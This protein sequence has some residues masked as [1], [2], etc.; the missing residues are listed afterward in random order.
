MRRVIVL[1]LLVAAAV[2]SGQAG[3]R[4]STAFSFVFGR[5][6]GNIAPF[7]VRIA[8]DGSVSSA[9]P[10]QPLKS[11]LAASDVARLA[12]VVAAQRF[13][14]LPVVIRCPNTL[15]DFASQFVTVRRAGVARRVLV[16]GDCSLRFTRLYSALAKAVGIKTA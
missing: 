2:L 11:R 8:A 16:H 9:G 7:T 13:F 6:G 12:T 1:A 5:I 3:A 15:P 4:S 10:V 14:A